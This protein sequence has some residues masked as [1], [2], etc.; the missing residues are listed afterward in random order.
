[1]KKEKEAKYLARVSSA[2]RL[3]AIALL[4]RALKKNKSYYM[5]LT[6]PIQIEKIAEG[7]CAFIPMLKGCKAYGHTAEEALKELE[8][9]R[10]GFIDVF[11]EMG[12]PIPEPNVCFSR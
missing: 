9:V 8:T 12:K 11:L 3:R 6:Y 7:F 1:M 2:G 10:E 5:A 4:A